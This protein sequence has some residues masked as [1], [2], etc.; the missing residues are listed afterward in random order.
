MLFFFFLSTGPPLGSLAEE[1]RMTSLCLAEGGEDFEICL[2]YP[3][4]KGLL[5]QGKDL[6]HL[7]T[8]TSLTPATS[9]LP[10]SPNGGETKLINT[11]AGHS[12]RTWVH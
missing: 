12:P 9:S 4:N 2:E 11:C 1:P 8:G 10:I 5:C 7:G 6:S 3:R